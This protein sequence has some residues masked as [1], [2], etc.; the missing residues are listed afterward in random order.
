[1]VLRSFDHAVLVELITSDSNAVVT[2]EAAEYLQN[3]V[4][5]IMSKHVGLGIYVQGPYG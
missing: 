5:I 2:N 3:Y 4:L 1:M